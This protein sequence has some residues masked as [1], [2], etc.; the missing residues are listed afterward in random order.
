MKTNKLY[1][2]HSNVNQNPQ[3]D[4][5][6]ATGLIDL[7]MTFKFIRKTFIKFYL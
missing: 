4:K 3:D 1:Q 5:I 6:L 7:K 2:H